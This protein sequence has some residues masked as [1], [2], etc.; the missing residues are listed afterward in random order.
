MR[1]PHTELQTYLGSIHYCITHPNIETRACIC[2]AYFISSS[3]HIP[4]IIRLKMARSEETDQ[5]RT[6]RSA[7]SIRSRVAV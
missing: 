5:I 6:E 2:T 4:V 1:T 3:V 7:F